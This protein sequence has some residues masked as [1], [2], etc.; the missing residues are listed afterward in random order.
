MKPL[1][2]NVEIFVTLDYTLVSQLRC[3][4]RKQQKK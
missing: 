3:H 1:E 2:G 4:T